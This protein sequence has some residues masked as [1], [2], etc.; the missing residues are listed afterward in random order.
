M[1]LGSFIWHMLKINTH[2]RQAHRKYAFVPLQVEMGPGNILNVTL[3]ISISRFLAPCGWCTQ[4]E[5]RDRQFM[6]NVLPGCSTLLMSVRRQTDDKCESGW[7][8]AIQWS[9][10]ERRW[11]KK[12]GG[13]KK[14]M[15]PALSS[16]PLFRSP[17]QHA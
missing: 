11:D 6:K 13:G 10:T 15:V 8:R 9:R 17:R 2:A 3:Y 12:L 7:S 4:Q 14:W 5:G 16:A 1:T